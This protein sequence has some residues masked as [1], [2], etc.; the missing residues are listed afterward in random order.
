ME[1][2]D[3]LVWRELCHEF[4]LFFG[5]SGPFFEILSWDLVGGERT[6]AI[7]A[8]ADIPTP[9]LR[10]FEGPVLAVSRHLGG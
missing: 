4:F 3:K 5:F 10:L 6:A 7:E 8:A 9:I 2:S 1:H